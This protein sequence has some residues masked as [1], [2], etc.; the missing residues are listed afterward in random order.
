MGERTRRSLEDILDDASR[1]MDEASDSLWRKTTFTRTTTTVNG[2]E[3]PDP[4]EERVASIEIK[5]DKVLAWIESQD[6]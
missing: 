3:V 6:K 1:L 4:L 2:E 5:L